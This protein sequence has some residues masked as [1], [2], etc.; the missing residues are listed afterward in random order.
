M[1]DINIMIRFPIY[2]YTNVRFL[3]IVIFFGLD[4]NSDDCGSRY[5]SGDHKKHFTS[6]SSDN[7]RTRCLRTEEDYRQVL[8]ALWRRTAELCKSNS[9]RSFLRKQ[10]K[11]SSIGLNSGTLF[12]CHSVYVQLL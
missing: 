4:V 6:S 9:L 12:T 3:V 7:D 5:I 11:L 2:D 8:D 1:E 10:G